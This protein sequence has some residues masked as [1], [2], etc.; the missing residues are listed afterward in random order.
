MP[1]K[2]GAKVDNTILNLISGDKYIYAR[3]VLFT[4]RVNVTATTEEKIWKD[5]ITILK[6]T[7]KK[8]GGKTL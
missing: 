7:G 5:V 6:K 4:K 3:N 1:A 2:Q 8:A